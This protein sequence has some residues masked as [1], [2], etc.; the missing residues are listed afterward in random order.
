[1]DNRG[2]GAR[3]RGEEEEGEAKRL[4]A[5][6]EERRKEQEVASEE[7]RTDLSD[8]TGLTTCL[9]ASRYATGWASLRTV[10]NLR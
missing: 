1:M 4:I 5:R 9:P 7:K 3:N 2:E 6:V 10:S 8:S